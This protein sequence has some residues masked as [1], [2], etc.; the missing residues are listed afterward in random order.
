[1]QSSVNGSGTVWETVRKI[2][3]M[4]L[5]QSWKQYA[6]STMNGSRKGWEIVRKVKCEWF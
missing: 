3:R 4:V 1:M 2:L 5:E 6:K